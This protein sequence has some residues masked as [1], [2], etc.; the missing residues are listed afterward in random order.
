LG[1]MRTEFRP[2][3]EGRTDGTMVVLTLAAI[4]PG[5]ARTSGWGEEVFDVLPLL[6][7]ESVSHHLDDIKL[8]FIYLKLIMICRSIFR[9]QGR[10]PD[11][12]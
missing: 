2:G 9:R 6:I 3:G 10:F 8:I 12:A 4:S 5:T 1:R 11:M 7:S